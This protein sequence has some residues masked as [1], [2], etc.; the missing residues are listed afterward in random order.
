VLESEQAANKA[1]NE[2]S[3]T[4]CFNFMLRASDEDIR[5]RT[6]TTHAGEL[7]RAFP[8]KF[9]SLADHCWLGMTW[10]VQPAATVKSPQGAYS[11][12]VSECARKI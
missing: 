3:A 10:G 12:S 8:A 4:N 2:P 11:H 6:C 7:A 5:C 1:A 9:A